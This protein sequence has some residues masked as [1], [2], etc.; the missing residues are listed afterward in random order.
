MNMRNTKKAFAALLCALLMLTC[1]AAIAES[2]A[3]PIPT[4]IQNGMVGAT[5][6]TVQ[7]SAQVSADPDMVTIQTNAF[8]K[9]LSMA[10]AQEQIAAIIESATSKL[11]E[12]GVL[13]EDIVTSNYSYY[14]NYDYDT[15]SLIGYEANHTLSIT[16]RDVE[17]LDSVIAV[18]T[19]CGLSQIFDVSFDVSTRGQLYRQALELA[20]QAAEEKAKTM[21]A[22]SGKTLTSL[23][24]IE[25]GAGYS[26][27]YGI[28]AR[29]DLVSMEI[30]TTGT[31]IRS[32]G[33]SVHAQ[34]T[35][36]YTAE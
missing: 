32:G 33:V 23:K 24:Y 1:A 36:V 13:G 18:L 29:S 3:A 17:M 5:E 34:V 27:G 6:I 31:G 8:A 12:L 19:D 9:A 4:A 26:D 16:C 22:A 2:P 21:A 14:P 10:D 11:M 30:K 35:A 28:N 15:N 7:G 20:I 25:E